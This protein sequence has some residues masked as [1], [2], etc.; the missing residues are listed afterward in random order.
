MNSNDSQKPGDCSTVSASSSNH[1]KRWRK[2]AVVFCL[3]TL[4]WGGIALYF[5]VTHSW[6]VI[7]EIHGFVD[8]GAH[9]TEFSPDG[10]TIAIS[11]G[12]R[13]KV[14]A[15]VSGKEIARLQSCGNVRVADFSSGG[16]IVSYFSDGKEDGRNACIWSA[17]DGR[18][19]GHFK[20]PGDAGAERCFPFFSPDNKWIVAEYP[21]GIITWDLSNL[22]HTSRI[23]ITRNRDPWLRAFLS[24]HPS[25]HEM[26]CADADGTL[27]KVNLQKETVA[28]LLNKQHSPVKAAQWSPNGKRLIVIDRND[29]RALILDVP[30]GSIHA[31]L[32]TENVVY[33]CFSPTGDRVMTVAKRKDVSHPKPT[34]LVWDRRTQIWDA[35]SG[36][37][38]CELP[39]TAIVTFSP[40]WSY[41]V[42]AGPEGVRIAN[43][44][45]SESCTYSGMF[46]GH[47]SICRFSSDNR[48]LARVNGSGL[49]DVMEHN[50]S[51][52][53]WIQVL[54]LYQFWMVVAAIAA[55]WFVW[56][57]K[58]SQHANG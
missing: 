25:S 23:K 28:P 58:S 10:T 31:T 39:T 21:D 42:E 24:W 17:A 12:E 50:A 9:C 55:L 26:T 32:P 1:R 7:H 34:P 41:Y 46:D 6:Q 19:V 47:G 35:S 36:N 4:L 51:I 27:F 20:L 13:G 33:A 8:Y 38:I 44:D 57:R 49:V 48:Y 3:A 16:K 54:L 14:L 37:L 29:A 5:R 56:G 11:H 52:R 43:F 15:W 30:V 40:D 45:N 22:T 53:S 18:I 2:L